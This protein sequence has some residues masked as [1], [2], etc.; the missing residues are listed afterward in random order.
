MDC[1]GFINLGCDQLGGLSGIAKHLEQDT[2]AIVIAQDLSPALQV[3]GVV[4]GAAVDLQTITN[5][6]GTKLG[7]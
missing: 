4:V 2:R 1:S 3:S 7:H 5:K 6:E